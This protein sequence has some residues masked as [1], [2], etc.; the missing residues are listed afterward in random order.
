MD[1]VLVFAI[2][3]SMSIG[4]F[5]GIVLAAVLRASRDEC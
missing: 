5:I 3:G 2:W 1:W 4:V